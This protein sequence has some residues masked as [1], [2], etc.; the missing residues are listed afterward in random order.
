MDL[1]GTVRCDERRVQLIEPGE[2]METSELLT[3]Q[4]SMVTSVRYS[5]INAEEREDSWV[6]PLGTRSAPSS[7]GSMPRVGPG[8]SMNSRTA[9]GISLPSPRGTPQVTSFH[10]DGSGRLTDSVQ[11]MMTFSP[12]S[13]L[14]SAVLQARGIR[15]LLQTRRIYGGEPMPSHNSNHRRASLLS[16]HT[17]LLGEHS[18]PLYAAAEL[19]VLIT[20]LAFVARTSKAPLYDLIE[21]AGL[22]ESRAQQILDVADADYLFALSER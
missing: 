6:A 18:L 20:H 16:Q 10:S 9:S 3:Q 17:I 15:P 19:P 4:P 7:E 11:S 13:L 22:A 1:P 21:L 5:D 14:R 2:R 12:R 8:R